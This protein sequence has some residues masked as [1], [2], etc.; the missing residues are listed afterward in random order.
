MLE[1]WP[2]LVAVVILGSAATS[3]LPKMRT[4]PE[5]CPLQNGNLID[6]ILFVE[7]S[8]ACETLC[9][10]SERCL[11]YYF[12]RGSGSN[13]VD[14][15]KQPPQC[16]LYDEC[17]RR[18]LA[19]TD[20]CPLNKEN[21]VNVHAFVSSNVECEKSCSRD[22]LCGYYK[23]F[24]VGDEKQPLMCYHLKS[25]APRI[26]R[27]MEC[28]L[29]KNNYI[30]HT[31]FTKS[32]EDCRRQCE[33]MGGCRF[34][35]WY[36]IHYSPA[37]NYCY[38][39]R[40]C[41]GGADEPQVAMVASGRHPGH[42]FLG[43]ESGEVGELVKTGAVCEVV[44]EKENGT[45]VGR[46]G[47]VSEYT[48]RRVLLCGGRDNNGEVRRDCIAYNPK[49]NQWSDHSDMSSAR[50][51]AASVVIKG[52][53]DMIVIGGLIDDLRTTTSDRLDGGDGGSGEWRGGP[54]LQEPRAKFCAVSTENNRFAILGGET[55]ETA[56][57][58]DLKIYDS[59]NGDWS[60]LPEMRQARKDHAC[61]MAEINGDKGIL[62]SG[63]VDPSDVLLESAEFYS[64]RTESWTE[65]SGLMTART[66][67]GMALIDGLPTV[68]GGVSS[69]EFL[70]SIEV[71]DNSVDEAAPL[72]MDWRI[73]A[74]AL[75]HPRYD[76]AIA[77][78]PIS[79]LPGNQRNLEV[80]DD[81]AVVVSAFQ[82]KKRR[83]R[84]K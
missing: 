32:S 19:A 33:D 40:S 71:L 9:T 44:M 10:S 46:A 77:H 82:K 84:R 41:E 7:N 20:K 2:I 59:D 24:N 75:M 6:T 81:D 74:H 80:C 17:N 22:D 30:D 29:E 25:C 58:A 15:R 60:T 55:D 4:A 31:L 78:I 69:R 79:A 16:F 42:Y 39:F 37:P 73:S 13:E 68:I 57:T 64:L 45:D 72:G 67:H 28:P 62:V 3:A 49:S 34:Y 61:L 83:R 11:F 66:E 21:T 56:A 23:Y 70:Q 35:Y 65:L 14:A 48:K 27:S 26:I 47:A 12:Y 51:E 50:E 63:G 76:F 43:K 1:M 18:V 52:S 8:T 36:P 5:E 53:G 54:Q 38:L